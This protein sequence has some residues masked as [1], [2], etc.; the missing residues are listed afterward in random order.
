MHVVRQHTSSGGRQ[1]NGGSDLL[2]E[3]SI[4]D[5]HAAGRSSRE[6]MSML[7][8]MLSFCTFSAMRLLNMLVAADPSS[9]MC[10]I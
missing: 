3:A 5:S 2:L 4:M 1:Q 6:K 9:M 10:C 8:C 7:D